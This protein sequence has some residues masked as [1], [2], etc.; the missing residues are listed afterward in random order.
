MTPHVFPAVMMLMLAAMT[1]IR[2]E[3]RVWR[4]ASGTFTVTAEMLGVTGDRVRLRK[5]DG[6]EIAVPL[7]RLSAEDHAYVKEHA[8]ADA[9]PPAKPDDAGAGTATRRVWKDDS[10]DF[11]VEAELVE[12]SETHV[13]LRKQDGS[14]IAVPLD[15]LSADDRSFLRRGRMS[16]REPARQLDVDKALRQKVS[17]D[18]QNTPLATV[19]EQL[20]QQHNLSIHIDRGSLR[21]KEI[22]PTVP[23]T[24]RA[25][26]QPLDVV[27]QEMLAPHNL[28]CYPYRNQVLV[29]RVSDELDSS[30]HDPLRIPW[31]VQVYRVDNWPASRRQQ[32]VNVIN[33]PEQQLREQVAPD[34]WADNTS[35]SGAGRRGLAQA[36]V[37][38]KQ[39]CFLVRQT[40]AVHREI[41]DRLSDRV[42]RVRAARRPLLQGL[43]LPGPLLEPKSFTVTDMPLD[44]F[45]L[46][47]RNTFSLSVDIDWDAMKEL[48][49]DASVTVS[50][51]FREVELM[52]ALDL[53]LNDIDC[54]WSIDPD[55]PGAGGITIYPLTRE[56]LLTRDY[57][58]RYNSTVG[59][60]SQALIFTFLF[61]PLSLIENPPRDYWDKIGGPAGI[62]AKG[63]DTLTIR[64][65][66]HMHIA[67]S[68]MLDQLHAV[69]PR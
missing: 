19:V 12:Q 67:M 37:V 54:I 13:R 51:A 31:V 27:L 48:G 4:D 55:D 43:K 5:E 46:Y 58:L 45:G 22:E 20:S 24:T 36:H 26:N 62:T 39:I 53:L 18:F 47:L 14:V 11:S 40:C 30:R 42:T 28:S 9:P 8:A 32:G 56:P 17:V 69:T 44:E 2:A 68:D 35:Q 25:R 52:T 34:T 50:G 41:E 23:I 3:Q 7:A 38:G 49:L 57:R 33:F 61:G 64:Q 60:D 63:T 29:I 59:I 6:S 15:R 21:H 66:L 1:G 10:G 65:T 16:E